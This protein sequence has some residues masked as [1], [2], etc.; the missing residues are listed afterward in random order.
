MARCEARERRNSEFYFK[1]AQ[2][3]SWLLLAAPGGSPPKRAQAALQRLAI[4]TAIPC[5][6]CLAWAHLEGL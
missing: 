2:Q 3:R 6:L 5:A 1:L 4:E